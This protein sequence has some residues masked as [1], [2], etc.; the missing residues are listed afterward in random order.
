[1]SDEEFRVCLY[2]AGLAESLDRFIQRTWPGHRVSKDS[3]GLRTLPPQPRAPTFLFLKREEVLGHITTL[4]VRLHCGSRVV[5]AHWLVGFMV[6]PEF[7]N[8]PIGPL[9]VRKVNQTLDLA[10]TLHVEESVLKIFLGLGWT[11][12]GVIPNHIRV[13]NAGRV[14]ENIQAGELTFLRKYHMAS[15]FIRPILSHS[16]TR[17]LAAMS[18]SAA[19]GLLATF[20]VPFRPAAACSKVMR[21]HGFDGS[22]DALWQRVG[23]KFDA[24]IVRD[25]CYLESR[26]GQRMDRYRLLAYRDQG[27]L[28]GYCILKIKQFSNDLRMGNLCAATLVDCLFDPDD[29]SVLQSLFTASVRQCRSEQVDVV[30]C[31]ASHSTVRELLSI[32]GFLK[33]AGNLNFACRDSKGSIGQ[34]PELASWH[35]MRGDSDADQNF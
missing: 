22:Y 31:T 24:L 10:M 19:C 21:E 14:L 4:P 1:M 16:F 35:L 28:R 30:I 15:N 2:D 8:R 27:E 34:T 29:L 13:L 32:N 7:R 3:S 18:C 11:H 17:A 12:V 33:I 26:Y 23:R 5:P 25:L 20:T 6:L 9:L